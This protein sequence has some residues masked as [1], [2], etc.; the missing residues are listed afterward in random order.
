MRLAQERFAQA[1]AQLDAERRALAEARATR[2]RAEADV[3]EV[4]AHVDALS[5]TNGLTAEAA[6]RIVER[7]IADTLRRTT[8]GAS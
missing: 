4:S 7:R 1:K 6:Q 2:Q 5:K 3:S 8:R